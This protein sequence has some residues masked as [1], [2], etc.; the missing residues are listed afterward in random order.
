MNRAF[1]I[2]ILSVALT[3]AEDAPKPVIHTAEQALVRFRDARDTELKSSLSEP[4]RKYVLRVSSADYLTARRMQPRDYKPPYRDHNVQDEAAWRIF[5]TISAAE[6]SKT[7]TW[8]ISY[9]T[10]LA[11]GLVIYLDAIT[12][13]VLYIHSVPEG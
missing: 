11:G 13:K 5:G 1:T 2:L 6:D 9:D 7:D 8:R 3:Y 10:G 12:G 4:H